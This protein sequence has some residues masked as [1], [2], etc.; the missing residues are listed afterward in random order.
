MH[1]EQV[2]SRPRAAGDAHEHRPGATQEPRKPQV[3]L[4]ATGQTKPQCG[5]PK[6]IWH[7]HVPLPLRPSL[8]TP[9]PLQATPGARVGQAPQFGPKKPTAQASQLEPPK[10]VEHEHWPLPSTPSEHVP[11]PP[12]TE[13]FEAAGHLR[14]HFAP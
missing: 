7:E 8:Q 4:S 1:A 10:P 3:T 11:W 9:W 14:V 2:P 6:P 13:P 5:P 12:Q